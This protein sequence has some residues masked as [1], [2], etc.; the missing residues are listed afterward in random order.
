MWLEKAVGSGLTGGWVGDG[1][2]CYPGLRSPTPKTPMELRQLL[3]RHHLEA[4]MH[5][6]PCSEVPR[7]GLGDCEGVACHRVTAL[8][9]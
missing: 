5:P 3:T 8:P 9:V 6:S 2:L 7:V 4:V 1:F